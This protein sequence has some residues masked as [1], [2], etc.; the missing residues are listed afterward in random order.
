[1]GA[2]SDE[3]AEF[4]RRTHSA[5]MI[6]VAEDG[7]AKAA[8]V[9]IVLV[10]D[11]LWSS[12]TRDRVRT[13]RLRRD[14]RCSLFVFSGQFQYLTLESTVTILEGPDA[15]EQSVRMFR[16]MQGRPE[17]P[18]SWFGGELDEAAFKAR[19]AE[20]G[21]LVYQFDVTRAYGMV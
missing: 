15:P 7:T 19:M 20:E 12:G 17:G 11:L 21:R 9:G 8:R 14:P 1:M 13:A 10:D 6:T 2:I 4:L 3:Q 18:L 5:A 16:E